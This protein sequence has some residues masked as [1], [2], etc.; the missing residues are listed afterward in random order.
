MYTVT[1]SQNVKIKQRC[2]KVNYVYVCFAAES[3]EHETCSSHIIKQV[4]GKET[5]NRIK[6][7]DII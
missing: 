7:L 1:K 2:L 6:G 5:L 4:E 3:N